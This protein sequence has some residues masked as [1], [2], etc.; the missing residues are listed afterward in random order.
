MRLL[1]LRVHSLFARE[2]TNPLGDLD[3]ALEQSRPGSRT[4][5]PCSTYAT[6]LRSLLVPF[7]RLRG[8]VLPTAGCSS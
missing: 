4:S 1:F 6:G 8:P 2:A 7:A 3:R 5:G